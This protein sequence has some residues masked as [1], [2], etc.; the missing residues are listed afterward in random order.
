M[1]PTHQRHKQGVGSYRALL[2][3]SCMRRSITLHAP[4]GALDVVRERIT[5][6]H[7]PPLPPPDRGACPV[8]FWQRRASWADARGPFCVADAAGRSGVHLLDFASAASPCAV[9]AVPSRAELHQTGS[10]FQAN[11]RCLA[12]VRQPSA[13][14]ASLQA[15][16]CAASLRY[17]CACSMPRGHG[18][19]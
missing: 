10:A 16:A 14:G 4:A 2:A 7:C 13:L 12:W 17:M 8:E 6:A 3:S 11:R 5:H 18:T 9:G 1:W 19:A 15:S